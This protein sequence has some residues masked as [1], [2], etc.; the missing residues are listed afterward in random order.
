MRFIYGS[1]IVSLIKSTRG[2]KQGYMLSPL[3][4]NILMAI[5]TKKFKEKIRTPNTF[6]IVNSL[7]VSLILYADKADIF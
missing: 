6:P 3:L 1:N 7:V 4:F 2:V 5:L